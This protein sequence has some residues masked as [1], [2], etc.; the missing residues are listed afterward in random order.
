[1]IDLR[2]HL[3]LFRNLFVAACLALLVGC[4][5]GSL[6][7]LAAVPANLTATP[8]D[9]SVTLAWTTSSDATAYTVKRGTAAGG[10]YTKIASP[11]STGYKDTSLTNGTAYY[12]VV[13]ATNAGGESANSNE[14]SATPSAAT[15]PPV[16]ANLTATPGDSQVQLTWTAS[17]GA[18]TYNVK[19]STTNGGPYTQIATPTSNSYTDTGLTNGTTY[20]YVVSAVGAGAAES[21]NSTQVSATPSKSVTNFGTWTN[22]TPS[23][24]DLVTP[25]G[26]GNYGANTIVVDPA[27][28]SHLY[29]EIL[30]QG[31]W[32]STDYGLTWTG[33]INTGTHGTDVGTCSGGIAIPPN[34]TSSVPTIYD[35]CIRGNIIGFFKSVDGGVNWTNY[36]I[37]ASTTDPTRLDYAYPVVDPYDGN[38]IL[39]T[40]HEDNNFVQSTDGGQTWTAVPLDPGMLTPA[41]TG[42]VSFINTGTAAST[43][44]TWLWVAQDS[45][46]KYGTWRTTNSGTTWVKVDPTEHPLG[47]AQT[48]QP[49]TSGVMFLAG[50]NGVMRST[51]Y[52]VTW[53]AVAS[54]KQESAVFGT[55]KNVYTMYGI[56]AGPGSSI[57]PNFQVAAQPGTGVWALPGTPAG[58][59]PGI[60]EAAVVNDGTHNV[61]VTAMWNGGVWRYVEP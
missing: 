11:T 46:H 18:T 25:L 57:D 3:Q 54:A 47:N 33:P 43:R 44:T 13:S 9:T 4:G 45:G 20:Y 38:H 7:P 12:Y 23:N 14:A 53:T 55:S 58:M 41:Q 49:D 17:T 26:C 35:A 27:N 60:G 52:G 16:P 19:R 6:T 28:P 2:P 30:C 21:A 61:L 8:G 50:T 10:P 31:I 42:V 29:V 39:L 34:S 48:Y 40:G 15:A 56:P 5:P 1:M 22:V 24:A 51:D 37:T 36:P 59:A 32:K